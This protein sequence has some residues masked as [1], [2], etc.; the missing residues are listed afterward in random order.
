MAIANT[1]PN[2]AIAE[3]L[4]FAPSATSRPASANSPDEI[5]RAAIATPARHREREA[6][7]Q[8][9]QDF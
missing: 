5:V 2:M 8:P 7:H 4:A 9:D 1:P 3:A 6:C